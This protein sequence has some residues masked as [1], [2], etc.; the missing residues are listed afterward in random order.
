MSFLVN[1]YH[2]LHDNICCYLSDTFIVNRRKES[3]WRESKMHIPCFLKLCIALWYQYS[4]SYAV[5]YNFITRT[6][7]LLFM[8]R[9]S[10]FL[11]LCVFIEIAFIFPKM[12]SFNLQFSLKVNFP[13][14]ENKLWQKRKCERRRNAPQQYI[15][16]FL[17]IGFFKNI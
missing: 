4:Q 9:K 13:C 8:E 11:F 16:I 12:F 14:F 2:L 1:V 10:N 5:K 7:Y 17:N 15:N 3:V 6:K